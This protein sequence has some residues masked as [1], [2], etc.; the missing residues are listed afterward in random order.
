MIKGL[1]SFGFTFIIWTCQSLAQDAAWKEIEDGN[2]RKAIRICK[3]HIGDTNSIEWRYSMA[4]AT[5]LKDQRR[6]NPW[7]YGQPTKEAYQEFKQLA[8]EFSDI[9]KFHLR[10]GLCLFRMRK[11]EE[12]YVEFKI[13][14][15]LLPLDEWILYHR[16]L[17]F[18]SKASQPSYEAHEL[19]ELLNDMQYVVRDPTLVRR[20][21]INADDI[22]QYDSI[23]K[24]PLFETI[25][26]VHFAEKEIYNA[27]TAS[28]DRNYKSLKDCYYKCLVFE[29]DSISRRPFL[30]Y[31]LPF[32][33]LKD[34]ASFKRL[35]EPDNN[36]KLHSFS[37]S[38]VDY[39]AIH[40]FLCK[41]TLSVEASKLLN[42]IQPY[43][44]A[45]INNVKLE[46]LDC[47][48]SELV[49]GKLKEIVFVIDAPE[50][51]YKPVMVNQSGQI[52]PSKK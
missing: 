3:R 25:D 52:I 5:Y 24:W 7:K 19:M 28:F 48:S 14:S 34:S 10:A 50:A 39:Y 30:S 12:A 13:A 45:F 42:N 22:A 33:E 40:E 49:I 46:C 43:R 29:Y 44:K 35:I 18:L 37:I 8:S 41:S 20:L 16:S 38:I 32:V 23:Y 15:Q 6:Y 51:A 47:G 27:D 11:L 4:V 9:P 1:F 26:I 31:S 17:C 36:L 21:Q 2:L